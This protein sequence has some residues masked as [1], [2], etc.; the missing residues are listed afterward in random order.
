MPA[1]AFFVIGG[2]H[3][4]GATRAVAGV[5]GCAALVGGW[6]GGLQIGRAL[7]LRAYARAHRAHVAHLAARPAGPASP[8]MLPAALADV[9]PR[10]G[11]ASDDD[12]G[13]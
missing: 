11:D 8:A 12:H 10:R 4:D 2:A 3:V 5:I 13:D 1:V 9:P 6:A 7:Q